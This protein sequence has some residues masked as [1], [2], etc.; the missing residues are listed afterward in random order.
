MPVFTR[1]SRLPD[2]A[3]DKG[4]IR[5]RE[6]EKPNRQ[7]ANEE[8]PATTPLGVWLPSAFHLP[9]FPAYGTAISTA[10]IGPRSPMVL[11]ATTAGTT[12]VPD[13]SA[14][15]LNLCHNPKSY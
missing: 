6:A 3:D 13:A 12:T 2:G 15:P 9:P 14:F 11:R 4:K 1:P 7:K 5:K 10:L 8:A